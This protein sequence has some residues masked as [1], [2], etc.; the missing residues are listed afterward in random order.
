MTPKLMRL[1]VLLPCLTI[2]LWAANPWLG[3]WKLNV[4]KSKFDP[5]PAPKSR[6]Q[7]IVAVGDQFR[8]TTESVAADGQASKSVWTGKWD[9]KPYPV[10]ASTPGYAAA[11]KQVAPDIYES[12]LTLNG[13]PTVTVRSTLSQ[14]GRIINVVVNGVNAK[15]EK[16]H[17]VTVWEKQ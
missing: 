10:E 16:V 17:N 1:A 9:G 14:N 6:I 12:T 7:T 8:T 11:V 3:T 15:G 2:S 5:G 4:A 13:K